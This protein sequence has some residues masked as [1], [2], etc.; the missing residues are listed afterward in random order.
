[1]DY[2]KGD[3]EC[4]DD[5]EGSTFNSQIAAL[6]ARL[7]IRYMMLKAV[8]DNG[9]QGISRADMWRQCS[10]LLEPLLATHQAGKAVPE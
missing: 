10:S 3:S 6:K 5:I 8:T 7:D 1:M 2:I 4:F 9:F